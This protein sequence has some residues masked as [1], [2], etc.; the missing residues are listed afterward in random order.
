M[1]EPR[2]VLR[3]AEEG[4]SNKARNVNWHRVE[5]NDATVAVTVTTT[6]GLNLFFKDINDTVFFL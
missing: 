3:G 2:V 5:V 4:R 6:G 1:D